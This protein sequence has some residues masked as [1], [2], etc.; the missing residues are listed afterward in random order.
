MDWT[1]LPRQKTGDQFLLI[2]RE[3]QQTKR[4]PPVPHETTRYW[5]GLPK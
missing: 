5:L 2:F 1:T 4:T 3:A